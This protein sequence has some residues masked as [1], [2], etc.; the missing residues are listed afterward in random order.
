MQIHCMTEFNP[1]IQTISCK[2]KKIS[3]SP[4]LALRFSWHNPADSDS[5]FLWLSPTKYSRDFFHMLHTCCREMEIELVRILKIYKWITFTKYILIQSSSLLLQSHLTV[6][7]CAWLY[8]QLL[9]AAW[10]PLKNIEQKRYLFFVDF[11]KLILH[12]MNLLHF[13]FQTFHF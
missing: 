7:V 8:L 1:L 5:A 12:S 11:Y 13:K 10:L 3:F 9:F 2:N 4:G 6:L